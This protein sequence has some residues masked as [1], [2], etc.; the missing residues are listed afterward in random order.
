[1]LIPVRLLLQ[2]D[3]SR[4]LEQLAGQINGLCQWTLRHELM[5]QQKDEAVAVLELWE[6]YSKLTADAAIRTATQESQHLEKR[7]RILL[8]LVHQM[9]SVE[10]VRIQLAD[11]KKKLDAILE[12]ISRSVNCGGRFEWVDSLLVKALRDGHWLLIDNVNLCTSSVLDRL[13][14]LLEPGGVLT[15]SERGVIDGE[16]PTVRPHPEFRLFLALDPRHGE[17][18][19]AMRNRGVEIYLLGP[20]EVE[21]PLV[22]AHS[23]LQAAGLRSPLLR[24]TL[25]SFHQSICRWS[26]STEQPT[27]TELLQAASLAAQRLEMFSANPLSCLDDACVDVYINS[28]R[29]AS[30]REAARSLLSQALETGLETEH[31][32]DSSGDEYH[33][34]IVSTRELQLSST[35]ARIRQAVCMVEQ[36]LKEKAAVVQ[37]SILLFY[38]SSSVR[39][40]DWRRNLLEQTLRRHGEQHDGSLVVHQHLYGTL[41]AQLEQITTGRDAQLL[42]L[43]WD[44]RWFH[45]ICQHHAHYGVQQSDRIDVMTN[46]RLSLNLF[47]RLWNLAEEPCASGQTVASFWRAIASGTLAEEAAPHGLFVALPRFLG[48]LDQTLDKLMTSADVYLN[49][50]EWVALWHAVRWRIDM[51]DLNCL[52]GNTENL[53]AT[54]ACMTQYWTWLQK[55]ALPV[56]R[57]LLQR[58]PVAPSLAESADQVSITLSSAGSLWELA[59]VLSRRLRRLVD[60]EPVEPFMDESH[61]QLARVIGAIFSTCSLG[62]VA[63][64]RAGQLMRELSQCIID[65][66]SANAA[67]NAQDQD[68]ISSR[69]SRLFEQLNVTGNSIT[70]PAAEDERQIWSLLDHLILLQHWAASARRRQDTASILNQSVASSLNLVPTMSAALLRSHYA[71]NSSVP[72]TESRLCH[73]EAVNNL[74]TSRRISLNFLEAAPDAADTRIRRLA[75]A[76]PVLSLAVAN[77]VH[78]TGIALGESI[79]KK[80]RLELLKEIL[81]NNSAQ[82]Q[83]Q[84]FDPMVND[85]LL[86]AEEMHRFLGAVCNALRLPAPEACSMNDDVVLQQVLQSWNGHVPPV[87]IQVIGSALELMR[88]DDADVCVGSAWLLLGLAR[89]VLLAANDN[90]DPVEKRK[91]KVSLRQRECERLGRFLKVHQLF[92]TLLTGSCATE[93]GTRHPHVAFFDERSKQLQR[94]N[95]E[96]E[97]RRPTWR[98]ANGTLYHSLTK[99]VH[100]Y[101]K[102][103]ASPQSVQ[104][105]AKKLRQY[106]ADAH[107]GK[108]ILSQAELWISAQRT[109]YHS[110][111]NKFVDYPDLTVPLL[112]GIGQ[113]IH[114]AEVLTRRVEKL[115]QSKVLQAAHV[116]GSIDDVIADLVERP[117]LLVASSDGG[118]LKLAQLCTSMRVGRLFDAVFDS[119]DE[120]DENKK[121]LLM[122]ALK[123]VQRHVAHGRRIESEAWTTELTIL[124][125]LVASWNASEDLERILAEEKASLYKSRTQ[126]HEG[127]LPDAEADRRALERYFPSYDNEFSDTEQILDEAMETEETGAAD[128]LNFKLTEQDLIDISRNH[129]DLLCLWSRSMALT[130]SPE[131]VDPA[132][133]RPGNGGFLMRYPLL[134]RMS[135]VLCP[136][137]STQFDRRL[138]SSHISF[139]HH[140]TLETDVPDRST[141][142]KFDFYYDPCIDE[143]ILCRPV[144]EQ[145]DARMDHLLSQWPGHATLVDIKKLDQ[146]ILGFAVDSPLMKVSDLLT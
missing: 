50:E 99:D 133:E 48:Q 33:C 65:T 53:D 94:Q 86:V 129:V 140:T 16:I 97:T 135:G 13:N 83:R 6:S 89:C 5:N 127:E 115:A 120:R 62:G 76:A 35:L 37:D 44:P 143:A 109:F 58:F 108:L 1:M 47:W 71:T 56:V 102:S 75:T 69:L 113:M 146:R 59:S 126:V 78:K 80:K 32:D 45:A 142:G 77:V 15:L 116:N 138:V 10:E 93:D 123:E 52:P 38:L 29:L 27:L 63:A 43:P 54:V 101:I 20:E 112:T 141:P 96:D 28:I 24:R 55:R 46:N 49:N 95:K 119:P 3:L 117:S 104:E 100:H 73:W 8:K 22:D 85:R 98:P 122:S 128:A 107:D 9:R 40:V 61:A 42:D 87:V 19:R 57:N 72:W 92:Q 88:V 118:A 124:D 84:T 103:V 125:A 105:L 137:L 79:E 139:M 144:L 51:K 70:G 68:S 41:K 4:S 11:M 31:E 34:P 26:A 2:G 21:Y 132:N 110:L 130:P 145:L 25:L 134:T 106:D 81:W 30:D 74:S 36:Q 66:C 7:I 67:G 23:I 82:L 60:D 64:E 18:S 136:S 17:I 39:D 121:M 91:L 111:K 90:V 114:G 131:S 14:A 12:Q